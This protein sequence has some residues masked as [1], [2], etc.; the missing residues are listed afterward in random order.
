MLRRL[1]R[2]SDWPFLLKLGIGPALALAA[3][4]LLAWVGAGRIAAQSAT[5]GS[6]VRTNAAVATLDEAS[7]QA[8]REALGSY[9]KPYLRA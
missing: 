6:V 4:G 5:I 8:I 9:L 7:K 3:L 1:A 2:I